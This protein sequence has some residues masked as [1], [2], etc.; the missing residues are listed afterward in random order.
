R[1][2]WRGLKRGS[3]APKRSMSYGD[4]DR[5][6]YS[7]AQHAV[8]NGYGKR[9]YFRAQL[10]ALSKRVTTTDS[11]SIRSSPD[12]TAFDCL[13]ST[14]QY[15]NPYCVEIK[16]FFAENK[17]SIIDLTT[18]ATTFTL[19]GRQES[20]WRG[21]K[22][23]WLKTTKTRAR[24]SFTAFRA[25]AITKSCWHRTDARRWRW[26]RNLVPIS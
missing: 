4:I 24:F 13:V 16:K 2:A 3:K 12:F 7:I 15:I 18:L 1:S 10:I 8:A 5:D 19:A 26:R 21:K 22:F 20:A 23:S 9:E 25:W 11:E 6:I 17:V 14:V